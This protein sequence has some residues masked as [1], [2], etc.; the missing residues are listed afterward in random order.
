MRIWLT[1]GSGFVGSNSL[2]GRGGA[3][4]FRRRDEARFND[5][6]TRGSGMSKTQQA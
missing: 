5:S 4:A 6:G 1:G 2:L 3:F